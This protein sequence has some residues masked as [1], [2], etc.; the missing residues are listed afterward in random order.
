M[1]DFGR[2]FDG[3]AARE[4]TQE[5]SLAHYWSV[6]AIQR[7]RGE[8]TEL[9]QEGSTVG[10]HH[11]ISVSEFLYWARVVDEGFE[12]ILGRPYLKIRS[13]T[14]DGRYVEAIALVRNKVTGK[15]LQKDG[16]FRTVI[17]N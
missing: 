1:G 11:F 3:D 9:I 6:L 12:R 10:E 8:I 17:I 4:V 5:Q 15:N 14:E 2:K 7:R 13:E 16:H